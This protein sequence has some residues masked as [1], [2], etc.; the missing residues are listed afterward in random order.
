VDEQAATGTVSVQSQLAG[1]A[2][3]CGPQLPAGCNADLR[4]QWAALDTAQRRAVYD[5]VIEKVVVS[6]PTTP[7]RTAF[8][9]DRLQVQVWF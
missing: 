1:L 8:D 5:Q 7:G 4:A 6:R 9:P 3:G 2:D